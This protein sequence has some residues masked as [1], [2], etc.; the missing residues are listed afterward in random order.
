MSKACD[1][2]DDIVAVAARQIV[3]TRQIARRQGPVPHAPVFVRQGSRDLRGC[4]SRIGGIDVDAGLTEHLAENGGIRGDDRK[5][6]VLRLQQGQPQAFV[7]GGADEHIGGVKQLIDPLG[8]LI[9]V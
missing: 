6:G 3:P 7:M 9:S 1:Q 2:A 5:A 8:G 4:S